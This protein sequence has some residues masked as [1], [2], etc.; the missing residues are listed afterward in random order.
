MTQPTIDT[1]KIRATITLG[2]ITVQTPYILSFNV[3]RQRGSKSTFSASLKV[4]GSDLGNL[5]DSKVVIQAGTFS[6]EKTIFTGFVLSSKPSPCW[7]DPSFIILNISGSD[8]LYKLENK[9]FTRRQVDAASKWAS[10]DSVTREAEVSGAFKLKNKPVTVISQNQ[11]PSTQTENKSDSTTA[12][13][14]NIGEVPQGNRDRIV[15]PTF[16]NYV[17]VEKPS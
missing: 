11:T 15:T 12:T 7:D 3:T 9:K 6:G 17:S 2:S 13:R 5:S 10:I 1:V 8:V 16:K 4:R 14:N